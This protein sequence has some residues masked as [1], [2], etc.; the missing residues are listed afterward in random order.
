MASGC[1]HPWM[2]L[3]FSFARSDHTYIIPIISLKSDIDFLRQFAL[4]RKLVASSSTSLISQSSLVTSVRSQ[5]A[6]LNIQPR[7][8]PEDALRPNE[9]AY[10]KS[11]SNT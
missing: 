9:S 3:H 1:L 2:Q 5:A 4:G 11:E 6:L 10:I 7:R 8:T